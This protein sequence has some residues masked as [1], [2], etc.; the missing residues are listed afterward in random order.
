MLKVKYIIQAIK[1]LYQETDYNVLSNT[2]HANV[3]IKAH[4]LQRLDNKKAKE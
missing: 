2:E 1:E 4:E 3:K